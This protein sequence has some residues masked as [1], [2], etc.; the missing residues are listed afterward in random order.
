M[1]EAEHTVQSYDE[2]LERL[3]SLVSR[4]GGLVESQIVRATRAMTT[5]DSDIARSVIDRDA[6]IDAMER[7]LEGVAV[8]VLALRQPMAIDLRGII[9]ALRVAADLERMGDLAANIAKRSIALSQSREIGSL[10]L[11]P[12]MAS[13]VRTMVTDVLDAYVQQDVAKAERVWRGD[14]DIDEMHNGLFRQLLTYMIEDPR[15]ITPCMHL[16]FAAKNLERIA[17]HATNVRRGGVLPPDRR[18]Q[19]GRTPEIR[20]HGDLRRRRG[21][22]VRVRPSV[23]LVEDEEDIVTMLRYNLERE[24]FAVRATG[25]GEEAL[26]M[27][28]EAPPD[29][30]ILDWMLPSVSGLEIC[31]SLRRS[32]ATRSLPVIMLT[33]RAE[34]EDRVR[35]LDSGADDYVPKPFSPRELVARVRAVLR[36]ARPALGAARLAHA[37]I[38]M[39]LET[40]RVYRGGRRIDPGADRIPPSAPLPRTPAPRVQPRTIARCGVGTRHLRRVAHRRRAHPAPAQGAQRR[41]RTGRDPHRAFGRLCAGG[42]R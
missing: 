30:A 41:R 33:A 6:E 20:R 39:D 18:T 5:R 40:F 31:R 36:R 22:A 15:N 3:T 42:H 17:D 14:R 16:A 11:L 32:P 2:D 4:M 26:A 24:G 27:V 35:G 1:A 9:G 21:G 7:E 19:P 29:V 10:W 37:D 28:A 38:E 12:G 34:E 13:R 8:T 25:D 23:L